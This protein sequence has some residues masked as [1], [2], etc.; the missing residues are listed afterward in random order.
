[1]EA[2]PQELLTF[3]LIGCSITEAELSPNNYY[4]M[5]MSTIFRPTVYLLVEMCDRLNFLLGT[6][7]SSQ[8]QLL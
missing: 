1:M 2:L 4:V 3:G 5:V 8:H 6:I 7:L